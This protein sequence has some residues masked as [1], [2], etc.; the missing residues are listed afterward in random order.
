MKLRVLKIEVFYIITVN[1]FAVYPNAVSV[2]FESLACPSLHPS[3]L[4]S[5]SRPSSLHLLPSLFYSVCL[6]CTNCVSG[7]TADAEL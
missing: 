2:I 3:L 5:L 4:P 6:L 1:T 7:M